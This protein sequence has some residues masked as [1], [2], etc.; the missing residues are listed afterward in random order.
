MP[1]DKFT[2]PNDEKPPAIQSYKGR[3]PKLSPRM[4]PESCLHWPQYTNVCI[5]CLPQKFNSSRTNPET[6]E[7]TKKV[8]KAIMLSKEEIEMKSKCVDE[9]G[10]FNF[11]AILPA[12]Y[13]K[14]EKDT[15]G[16]TIGHDFT[17]A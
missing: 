10:N 15:T 4:S 9:L 1:P 16:M 5:Y 6:L 13:W 14:C 2:S 7:K 8:N 12:V 17:N 3:R 11:D